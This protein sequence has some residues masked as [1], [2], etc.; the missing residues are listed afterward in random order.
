MYST[1]CT[2][3]VESTYHKIRVD[4]PSSKHDA[5]VGSVETELIFDLLNNYWLGYASRRCS[6][7][8]Y[9]KPEN[10]ILGYPSVCLS[11]VSCESNRYRVNKPGSQL[12][13]GKSVCLEEAMA[14]GVGS[15]RK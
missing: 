1:L 13:S 7:D 9:W 2:C 4:F 6:S 11:T 14:P 8:R 3:L 15:R 5:K 12:V 10:P